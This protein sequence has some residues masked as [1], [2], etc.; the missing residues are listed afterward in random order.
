MLRGL[1]RDA[2]VLMEIADYAERNGR[3]LENSSIQAL[4]CDAL[5][6]RFNVLKAFVTRPYMQ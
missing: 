6:V 2:G 5:Y 4:R 1:Y 3:N